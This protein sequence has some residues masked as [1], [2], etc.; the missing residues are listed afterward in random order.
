MALATAYDHST[1]VVGIR[2][3]RWR[4]RPWLR[5]PYAVGAVRADLRR[6]SRPLRAHHP[7]GVAVAGV[8]QNL[9]SRRRRRS[10]L[11]TQP[12]SKGSRSSS[13]PNDQID[14]VRT[15]PMIRMTRSLITILSAR[16]RGRRKQENIIRRRGGWRRE[17]DEL[18][19]PGQRRRQPASWRQYYRLRR[20]LF[21]PY[22][23]RRLG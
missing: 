19:L 2:A 6:E 4:T 5:N 8:E 13:V 14:S 7:H 10:Y 16:C 12:A 11:F 20:W 23:G 9:L 1:C 18:R 17:N 3:F 22:R 15:R 21:G